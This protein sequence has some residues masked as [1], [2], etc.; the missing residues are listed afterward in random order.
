MLLGL[1]R[2]RDEFGNTTAWVGKATCGNMKANAMV[3]LGSLECLPWCSPITPITPLQGMIT[4][5]CMKRGITTNYRQ[6]WYLIAFGSLCA[7]VID[8]ATVCGLI[9]H[10]HKLAAA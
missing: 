2:I 10:V 8:T 4:D 9:T 6:D 5:L 7:L 1:G 3:G